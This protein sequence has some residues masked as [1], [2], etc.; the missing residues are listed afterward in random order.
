MPKY[1]PKMTEQ[2]NKLKEGGIGLN[3]PMLV[4]S[5]YTAWSIKMKVY[6][7]AQGVWEAVEAKGTSTTPVSDRQDQVALATIYQG[8]P[9]DIL[10]AVAEKET[11]KEA[12][13]AIKTMC[14][15]ADRAKTAKVQTLKSE[16]ESLY[17]NDTETL[18]EFC[19]KLNGLVMNIRSLGEEMKES[20]VV[21]K[22]LRAVPERFLQIVSSIEQ[23]GGVATMTIDEAVGSL[24]AH[25]ERTKSHEGRTRRQSETGGG[26]V[27]LTEEEW[28][29]KESSDGKILLTMEEWL[30]RSNSNQRNRG[31]DGG[32]GSGSRDK[33]KMRCYNCSA[34]G[35][36]AAD[37]KKP[38]KEKEQN[39]EMNMAQI[40]DDAPALLLA[41]HKKVEDTMMLL[42]ETKVTPKLGKDGEQVESNIWYLDNGASNHM[43][44]VRSKFQDLD[45]KVTGQ[46]RFGDGSTVEIKGKG[47]VVF[48]CKNGEERTLDEVYYIPMLCNNII[49]LG[50]LSETGNKVVLSGE[51]LW[52]YGKSGKLLMKVKRSPNR[53]YKLIIETSKPTCLVLKTDELSWLWHSR[54]GHVNFQS[55]ILMQ[56]GKMVEGLPKFTQPK[57]VCTDCLMSKQVR[58][59]FPSQSKFCAT[60][61]LELVH[62]DLCDPISPETSGGNKYFMLLVDDYSRIMWVYFLKNKGEALNA[63]KR[64]KA[65]VED[66]QTKRIGT[67]RTDRGGEF[68]SQEF[69][70]YCEEHGITRNL[71]APYSP[72]QNGVVERRNR[73]VV[74][75]ARSLLKQMGLPLTLWGE[76]VRHSVYLLNRLPTRSLTGRTPYEAWKGV[77]PSIGHIKVFGCLTHM[78]V[79]G[80]RTTKLSDRSK[81]VIHL[82]NEPGT[83]AYRLYDPESNRIQV[84]RDVIFEEEK[85]W[86]WDKQSNMSSDQA[87]TFTLVNATQFDEGTVEENIDQGGG[88]SSAEQSETSH[89]QSESQESEVEGSE[90]S[91]SE[92]VKFRSLTDIYNDTEEIE[93]DDELLLMGI[94]EP[95]NYREAATK[96][97]WMQAMKSEM[98]S[99][100]QNHTWVLTDR[101]A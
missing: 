83:K 97:N 4:R 67:L 55:L 16:F 30:K 78:K 47:S 8:I 49:S 39:Q 54:L 15:G 40:E 10:L 69:T 29:K 32:R 70:H 74:S 87:M 22:L 96:H 19:A 72:Q 89:S 46:V 28:V 37:C 85:T 5:N 25:E 45:E 20:Y 26:Q 99:I 82:G 92:P 48:A 88:D 63:F 17:M 84:S 41:E 50:Q 61:A 3:Y 58:K 64:F 56:T 9:E 59:S 24:K 57:G 23:F 51:Y 14:Q 43:T 11:A 34:F 18:D 68:C 53:L 73:T 75:M 76:A 66:G 13:E 35:H 95:K 101:V 91:S 90:S 93:L 86:T 38:R 42:N 80:V 79:P 7:K 44:G 100:E 94:D 2:T 65:H 36:F 52:V 77:K 33:S 6:M 81:M 21:K 12:W 27:L 62:C 71:T 98:K 60:K 31:R 1:M